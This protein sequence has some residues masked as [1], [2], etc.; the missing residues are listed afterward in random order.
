M[1][2]NPV[3]YRNLTQDNCVE[4]TFDITPAL[5]GEQSEKSFHHLVG[6]QDGSKITSVKSY[7][8]FTT[9]SENTADRLIDSADKEGYVGKEPFSDETLMISPALTP[10]QIGAAFFRGSYNKDSALLLRVLMDS[11]LSLREVSGLL[12]I[13]V[14]T[15]KK[16]M[17]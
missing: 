10:S 11:G 14:Q 12:N 7:H 1:K 15:L 4:V 5:D 16:F 13:P 2:I 9:S 8:N 3:Y 6:T 17:I